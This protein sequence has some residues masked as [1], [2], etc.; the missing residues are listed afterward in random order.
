[1]EDLKKQI[2]ETNQAVWKLIKKWLSIDWSVDSNWEI[3][4][5][6]CTKA[7]NELKTDNEAIDEF[8]SAMLVKATVLIEA[9]HKE[10]KV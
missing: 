5:N 6:D 2:F 10:G 9:L 8:T 4:A 3:M 7:W 1:M